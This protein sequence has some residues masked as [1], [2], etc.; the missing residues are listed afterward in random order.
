MGRAAVLQRGQARGIICE[1]TRTLHSQLRSVNSC[2]S[3][4]N[5]RQHDMCSWVQQIICAARCCSRTF[6]AVVATRHAK[7]GA[8]TRH[9]QPSQSQSTWMCC[10]HLQPELVCLE[11]QWNTALLQQPTMYSCARCPVASM[12]LWGCA[13]ATTTP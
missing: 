9:M 7:P 13:L 5:A 3:S 6:T 11:P 1:A 10:S 4:R 8:A 2:A 12:A